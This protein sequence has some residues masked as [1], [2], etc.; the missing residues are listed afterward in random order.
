M[1]HISLPFFSPKSWLVSRHE[2]LLF[3][4]NGYFLSDIVKTNSRSLNDYILASN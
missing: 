1:R 4:K 2:I 3:F